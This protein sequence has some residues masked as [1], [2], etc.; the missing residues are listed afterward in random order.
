MELI[1]SVQSCFV[2]VCVFLCPAGGGED[3]GEEK[4]DRTGTVRFGHLLQAGP[5]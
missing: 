1:V 4:E 2:Y 3:N 5:I